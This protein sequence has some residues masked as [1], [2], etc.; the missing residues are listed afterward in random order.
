MQRKRSAFKFSASREPRLGG[1]VVA[2]GR[3]FKDRGCRRPR[4]SRTPSTPSLSP[5]G[6]VFHDEMLEPGTMR[7]SIEVAAKGTQEARCS[8][9]VQFR[10]QT[11]LRLPLHAEGGRR[12]LLPQHVLLGWLSL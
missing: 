9:F 10:L 5:G 3:R 7:Q 6:E 2:L 8:Y 4:E 11:S 12:W 1:D